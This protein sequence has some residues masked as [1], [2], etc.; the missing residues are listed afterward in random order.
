MLINKQKKD[1]GDGPQVS[2]TVGSRLSDEQ[3]QQVADTYE[4]TLVP[5]ND[6]EQPD[7]GNQM[8]LD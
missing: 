3:A 1:Y 4:T 2:M 7:V 8:L 6:I 5:I